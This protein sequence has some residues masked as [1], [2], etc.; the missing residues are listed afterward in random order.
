MQEIRLILFNPSPSLSGRPPAPAALA[1]F[2]SLLP[3]LVKNRRFSPPDPTEHQTAAT[4]MVEPAIGVLAPLR[5]AWVEDTQNA[6]LSALLARSSTETTSVEPASL[7]LDI[8]P[9]S[10]PDN[11]GTSLMV[12]QP[13]V[14]QPTVGAIRWRLGL[15]GLTTLNCAPVELS[16]GH[17]LRCCC[18]PAAPTNLSRVALTLLHCTRGAAGCA[19]AA[20]P[21]P[22]H[23]YRDPAIVRATPDRG[24]AL[25][26]PRRA[27]PHRTAPHRPPPTHPLI[28]PLSAP[29]RGHLLSGVGLQVSGGDLVT[30]TARDWPDASVVGDAAPRCRFGSMH[31][32][33]ATVA[34]DGR[35]GRRGEV[36]L[37]CTSPNF[38]RAQHHAAGLKLGRQ[39]S[40]R[41]THDIDGHHTPPGIAWPPYWV[42]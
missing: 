5:D 4:T 8:T 41:P 17:H 32:V 12:N 10:G 30:V 34:A 19:P 28:T 37:V 1:F 18:T 16:V 21:V 14:N 7:L 22:F 39:E 11:G 20:A 35:T 33:P 2:L 29:S 31:A 3:P 13:T 26:A 25:Q 38:H 9:M 6:T 24:Q 15:A 42:T 27:A 40:P 23:Y 36:K